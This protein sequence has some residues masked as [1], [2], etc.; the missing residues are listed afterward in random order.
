MQPTSP[1]PKFDFML[2]NNAQ[3]KRGL[4]LPQLSK[5][6]KIVAGAIVA[7]ILLVIISSV[8]SG[9][10]G[11]ATKQITAALARGQ[12]TLRVTQ[13]TQQQLKL[14]DPATQAL[15]AT[16]YSSLSSDQQQLV[17]YLAKSHIKVSKLELATDG[18]KTTDTQLQTASQNNSLDSAYVTYLKDSLAK[19]QTDLQEAYKAAG[20]NGQAI[21]KS[22]YDS[23]KTLLDNPPLKS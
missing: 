18:D 12:E 4:G 21:L 20:P 1:D 17:A 13:L 22:A 9:H 3:P 8:L 11:G 10:K 16:V 19:Y 7:V 23:T 6:I 14:Q 5:P 2:K 15:A